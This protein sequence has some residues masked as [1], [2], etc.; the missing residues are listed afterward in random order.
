MEL[1]HMDKVLLETFTMDLGKMTPNGAM[2]SRS[3]KM[4]PSTKG[5]L[6]EGTD[7]AMAL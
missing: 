3:G 2:G 5:T 7:K 6:S 4:E 1:K